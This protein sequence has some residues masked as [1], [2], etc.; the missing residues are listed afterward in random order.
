MT[1]SSEI[2]SS[3]LSAEDL[4]VNM[5]DIVSVT[6]MANMSG[7]SNTLKVPITELSLLPSIAPSFSCLVLWSRSFEIPSAVNL[8]FFSRVLLGLGI[9]FRIG[10]AGPSKK[11]M[12][13]KKVGLCLPN[14]SNT[15]AIMECLPWRVPKSCEKPAMPMLSS[16]GCM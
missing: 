7:K 8:N 14:E 9:R 3:E 12:I 4:T 13:W 6:I 2:C 15:S 10:N 16:L 1:S 5:Q 11:V